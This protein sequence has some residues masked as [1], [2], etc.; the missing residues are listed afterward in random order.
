MASSAFDRNVGVAEGEAVD[1][2]AAQGKPERRALLALAA[3]GVVLVALCPLMLSFL[4]EV[5]YERFVFAALAQGAVY[6]FAVWLVLRHRFGRPAL[7][8]IFIVAALARA[9][10]VPAPAT[11]STDVARYVWDG[12]VQAAGI[13]PYRYVPADEHLAELRDQAIYPHINRADYA[14]TIYPPVAQ[15]IFV[16]AT[17]ASETL[18]MMRLAMIGF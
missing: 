15:M 14:P 2:V 18:T 6:A 9:I 1:S 16:L 11:L 4:V 5:R 3:A 12:R 13:N 17:R 8:V 7:A 10:A